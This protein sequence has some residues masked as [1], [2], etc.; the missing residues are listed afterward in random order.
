MKKN[1]LNWMTILIAALLCVGFSS[2]CHHD[3][4]QE[5]IEKETPTLIGVWVCDFEPGVEFIICFKDDHTGYYYFTGL[6]DKDERDDFSYK[7]REDK[8]T[9]YYYDSDEDYYWNETIEYDLSSNGKSLTLYG[10]DDND[11]AV[12]HF[13]KK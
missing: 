13:K 1:L 7:V 6:D 2:C 8:I 3:D 12:L 5:E 11:M 9:L 4:D 10:F